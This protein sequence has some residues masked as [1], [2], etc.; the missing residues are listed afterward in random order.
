MHLFAHMSIH[1]LELYSKLPVTMFFVRRKT[2]KYMKYCLLITLVLITILQIGCLSGG[3]MHSAEKLVDAKD[4]SG[5]I[6]VYQSI[7]N[8]KPG[9]ANARKAQL[10]IGKLYIE[11]MNQPDKGIDAY[12]AVIAETPTSDEAAEA[13]YRLGIHSFHKQDYDT[14]QLHFEIIV[15]QFSHLELSQNAHLMLAKS[16]EKAEKFEHAVE[17]YDNFAN[18]YPQSK[19][20]PQVLK[21]KAQIQSELLKDVNGAIQTLQ[22]LIRKYNKS[23][24]AESYIKDAKKVLM[25]ANLS[26]F[27]FGAYPEAPVDYPFQDR[28]WD[29]DTPE[30]ELLVRLRIKLWKQG[31]K[32][33]GASY[34]ENGLVYPTI[35]GVIYVKWVTIEEGDPKLVGRRYPGRVMGDGETAKKWFSLYLDKQRFERTDIKNDPKVSGITVY[36]LPDG[37]ID[38][39]KFLDLPKYRE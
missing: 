24:G 14:A 7:I 3:V 23:K 30:H 19:R 4:Y 6:E 8:T 15:N 13:R 10:A 1:F 34:G 28:L 26:P 17:V 27:G 12:E 39:Y 25:E 37:G 9:T 20:A 21:N 2:V 18:R 32:T 5:A 38:P 31:I 36:E 22:L 16:F 35:S 11:D 29:N 33:K